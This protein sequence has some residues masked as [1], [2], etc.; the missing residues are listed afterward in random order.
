MHFSLLFEGN[1]TSERKSPGRNPQA[2]TKNRLEIAPKEAFRLPMQSSTTIAPTTSTVRPGNCSGCFKT[3]HSFVLNSPSVC[4]SKGSGP[5]LDLVIFILSSAA[6]QNARD[7]IRNSWARASKNNSSPILRYVFL[8]ALSNTS[9]SLE[10]VRAERDKF[11]DIALLD[12]Q[13]SYDLLTTKTV[14]GF[15]W[16][17][18]FCANARFVMKTDDDVYV[19]V[20]NVVR[21]MVT[22]GTEHTVYGKC[23]TAAGPERRPDHKWFMSKALYPYPVFPPYCTGVGY[24]MNMA[25]SKG[26]ARVAPDI[27][28]F[29][30]EDVYVGMCLKK[31]GG[32]DV[33]YIDGF[34]TNGHLFV[35]GKTVTCGTYSSP[36]LYLEHKVRP[37]QMVRIWGVCSENL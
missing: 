20:T 5:S 28:F 23:F 33:K 31:I 8:L 4:N 27:P 37:E 15:V 32:I 34:F 11:E 25:L 12:Y 6:N 26:I 21:L 29:P 1:L 30:L 24:V 13:D 35:G 14:M 18:T 7:G 10:K 17:E 22:N 16:V 9:G 36:D 3:N 2:P 19:N